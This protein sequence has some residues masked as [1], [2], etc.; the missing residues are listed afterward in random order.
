MNSKS[1]FRCRIFAAK[2]T[3]TELIQSNK[4]LHDY[5]DH[6]ALY[7]SATD[8]SDYSDY[9][10]CSDGHPPLQDLKFYVDVDYT[11]LYCSNTDYT[12]ALATLTTVTT[13]TTPTS[14]PDYIYFTDYPNCTQLHDYS[15]YSDYIVIFYPQIIL[16]IILKLQ[17]NI[18]E[19][20]LILM[21][22][23]G[24]SVFPTCSSVVFQAIILITQ[25]V[26]LNGITDL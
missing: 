8:H 17:W 26:T 20:Q 5:T 15:D 16:H 12:T 7:C 1:L 22:S 11:A 6:T 24:L 9:T 21:P 25:C 3:A 19:I 14:L 10:D 2:N 18:S 23:Y 13:F 4:Q